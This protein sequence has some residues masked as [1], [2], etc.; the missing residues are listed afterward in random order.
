MLIFVQNPIV[1][2]E[3]NTNFY[4]KSSKYLFQDIKLKPMKIIETTVVKTK[5]I[6][7]LTRSKPLSPQI[8][9]IHFLSQIYFLKT[10]DMLNV[11]YD[12]LRFNS[13]YI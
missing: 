9:N 7:W 2:Y 12:K 3:M 5:T 13:I 4:K 1:F 6:F 10:K 11:G 8:I